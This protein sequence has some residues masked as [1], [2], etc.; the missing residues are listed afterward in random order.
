MVNQNKSIYTVF[1]LK[2]EIHPNINNVTIPASDIVRYFGLILD[3]R[4]TW[5]KHF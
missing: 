3:K 4:L 1:T 2:Q 5:N